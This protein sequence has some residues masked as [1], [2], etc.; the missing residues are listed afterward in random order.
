MPPRRPA[1]VLFTPLAT[2]LFYMGVYTRP[3]TQADKDILEH[4]VY[5]FADTEMMGGLRP[6]IEEAQP[7]QTQVRVCVCVWGGGG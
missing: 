2:P 4:I 3:H 7:V 5:D 6:S 1:K